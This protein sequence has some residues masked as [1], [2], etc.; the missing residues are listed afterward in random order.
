VMY[1]IASTAFIWQWVLNI[2]CEG[3]AYLLGHLLFNL[4]TAWGLNGNDAAGLFERLFS[5]PSLASDTESAFRS[6][7]SGQCGW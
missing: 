5:S 6:F 7:L 1:S 2:N 4:Y 3:F